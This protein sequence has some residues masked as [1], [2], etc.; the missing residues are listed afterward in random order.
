MA[1]LK[2]K[3]RLKGKTVALQF[4]GCNASPEEIMIAFE[5]PGFTE[6][7]PI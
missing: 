1:V 3:E 7:I 2:L 5:R 4:S 6:V